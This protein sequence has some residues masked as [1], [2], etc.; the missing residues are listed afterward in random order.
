MTT[1]ITTYTVEALI[2]LKEAPANGSYLQIQDKSLLIESV[3]RFLPGK[4]LVAKAI[5]DNQVV[6]AK[7]FLGESA[8]RHMQ[9]EQDGLESFTAA[10]IAT[11]V[12]YNTLQTQN[13]C[14]LTTE[15]LDAS[16]SLDDLWQQDLADEQ[17]LSLLKQAV[18][19][20][21]TLHKH[22]IVHNDP[23][24]DN[25][26]MKDGAL[27]LIDGGGT[28]K[29]SHPLS[30]AT[31]LDN[32]GFFLSVLFPRFDHLS[33]Q[34]LPEYQQ[35]FPLGN[36]SEEVLG[37]AISKRR[38]WRERYLEKIFRTC[39][40][41]V[42]ES[43]FNKFQVINRTEIRPA[44]TEFMADPEPLINAG[45]VLK[46]GSTNTVSIV[47]LSDQ[48]QVFV[49][50]YKSTKG[51]LHW[52]LRGFRQSRARNGWYTAHYLLRL[53]GID[54]PK[55][56][57]LMEYKVGPFV[58]CSYLVTAFV[59]AEDALHYFNELKTIT[60]EATTRSKL[61]KDTLKVLKDALFFHGDMKATNFLFAYGHPLV[62]DLDQAMILSPG[63]T[64]EKLLKKDEARFARNWP[65]GSIA[66]Q[67][68]SKY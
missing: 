39:T 57:A 18:K 64:A 8:K 47:T 33:V 50:R 25:F 21:A 16:Q 11:P 52:F 49:K 62:I 6:L 48:T 65:A 12:I 1:G 68:F 55:P 34:C 67:L 60:P 61:L 13:G 15:F 20:L 9:R 27:Y 35:I 44:L 66:E 29:E 56:I 22:N 5:L 43:K 46:R 63:N 28:K 41:F 37:M 19:T 4:R 54:T 7:C 23:H 14:L 3:L 26:L 53:L 17:R 45:K 10:G 24:L 40:D 58:T 59:E 51:L 2:A 42:A 38:K 36:I 30:T 31:A 32:L